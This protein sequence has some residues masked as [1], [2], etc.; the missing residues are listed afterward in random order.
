MSPKFDMVSNYYQLGL[1]D[2]YKVHKAVEKGWITPAE[3]KQ[4][5]GQNYS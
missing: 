3:F 2:I 1:W 5:T 4:I